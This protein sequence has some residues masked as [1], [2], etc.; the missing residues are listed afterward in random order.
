MSGARLV[1]IARDKLAHGR[2]G[3]IEK[4]EDL[5]KIPVAHYYNADRYKQ[6]VD[7]IFPWHRQELLPA[8][9]TALPGKSRSHPGG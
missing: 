1:E 2:A 8:D 5:M 9:S 7:R 4:A 3:T 6:K